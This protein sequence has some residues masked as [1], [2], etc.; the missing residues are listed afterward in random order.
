MGYR[1]RCHGQKLPS[2]ESHHRVSVCIF[3]GNYV[4]QGISMKREYTPTREY[5]QF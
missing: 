2:V 5:G 1:G 4:I 3:A